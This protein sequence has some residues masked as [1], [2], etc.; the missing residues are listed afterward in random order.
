MTPTRFQIQVRRPSN[1]HDLGEVA[2]G[3]FLFRDGM[4]TL[5]DANAEPIPGGF[6]AE[7]ASNE[8]P[9]VIAKALFRQARSLN[10][11]RGFRDPIR[12][13]PKAIV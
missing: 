4:V 3:H 12:Y 6:N 1:P 9:V 11:N 10:P 2:I 13:R 5:C 8:S 7:V